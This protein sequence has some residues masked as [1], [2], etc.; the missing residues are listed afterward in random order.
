ME[1]VYSETPALLLSGEYDPITPPAWAALA[2]ETL[3]MSHTYTLTGHRARRRPQQ[4]LRGTN[5]P[6]FPI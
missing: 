3:P 4:R 1:A 5:Y 2:A 6:R